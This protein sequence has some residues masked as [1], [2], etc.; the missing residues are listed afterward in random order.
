[1]KVNIESYKKAYYTITE[2]AGIFDIKESTLRY[3]EKEFLE[4]KPIKNRSGNRRYKQNDI[5]IVKN[6]FELLKEKKFTIDGA[7]IEL[8]GKLKA[9]KTKKEA[10]KKLVRIKNK[11]EKLKE[12][13]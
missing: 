10:I 2:V 6:I 7:K 11:L 9:E 13:L 12:N 1:M 3:W 4:L 5:V 8:K